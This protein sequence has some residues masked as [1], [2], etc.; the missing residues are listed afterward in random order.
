MKRNI[1]L[2]LALM[3][4]VSAA[5]AQ[6]PDTLQWINKG[7][8]YSCWYDT[9]PDFFDTTD[10]IYSANGPLMRMQCMSGIGLRSMMKPEHVDRPTMILGVAVTEG[11][12]RHDRGG[13][14]DWEIERLTH[15]EEYVY[16]MQKTHEGKMEIQDSARWDTAAPKYMKIALNADTGRFGF[17]I[18]RVYEAR[19]ATP[20]IVDSTFYVFTSRNGDRQSP[21]NSLM[22]THKYLPVYPMFVYNHT[23]F[24]EPA[25]CYRP[26]WHTIYCYTF[27]SQQYEVYYF[28]PTSA[29]Y[30][31][32][33]PM[34]DYVNLR[35]TSADSTMGEAGPSARVSRG[36]THTI[37]ATPR[38]GYRFTHWNDSVTENPRSVLVTGDTL[39]TAYYD[40][41]RVAHVDVSS[42][43]PELGRVT[44][45]GMYN[46]GD[47]AYLEAIPALTVP[48]RESIA[49]DDSNGLGTNLTILFSH[50]ND[51]DTTNPRSVLVT[52][53]TA[54]TAFFRRV[55][56]IG[57][58]TLGFDIP[59]SAEGAAQFT[60]APNPTHG[61]V[62]LSL[63][64]TTSLAAHV[65][66]TD[67]RGHE[68]ATAT[69]APGASGTVIDTAPLP[70][71]VYF[72]TVV[73][74][75]HRAT[76]KLTVE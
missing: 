53:D 44:G 71:G 33:F 22:Y 12:T 58:D 26:P 41:T 57:A 64:R 31:L 8:H 6:T 76:R 37:R 65:T 47:T 5:S 63:A 7:Y 40:T 16:I 51:G 74:A 35:V 60:L 49:D 56:I 66:V 70:R 52:A 61:K 27:E 43:D 55:Y 21:S 75:P 14:Y 2:I 13:V 42:A 25:V 36:M 20:I 3:C 23:S 45:G 24:C 73:C 29:V 50:W 15:T 34:V 62:A 30:G 4:L 10:Y 18:I 38:L 32:Y 69:I 17:K 48:M 68:V 9:C 11:T 39:F 19:F 67:C 46:T 72:V 54:F 28:D 59:A 1:P